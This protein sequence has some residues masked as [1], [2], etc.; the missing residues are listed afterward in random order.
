MKVSER[1]RAEE[2]RHR[3]RVLL[4]S[5][6][7]KCVIPD[8]GQQFSGEDFRRLRLPG[9]YILFNKRSPLYV[10]YGAS[11]LGRIGWRHHGQTN[12]AM[13]KC[14][15]VLL[16]PCE[17]KNA[18]RRLEVILISQLK[19]PFNERLKRPAMF[20]GVRPQWRING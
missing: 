15:E 17:S 8:S 14:D 7:W 11:L 5:E 12:L 4:N 16:F 18:A 3:F 20:L 2:S 19:P 10:G 1:S 13:E 6:I 9:V